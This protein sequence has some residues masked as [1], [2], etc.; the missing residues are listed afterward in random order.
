M[1]FS[2][3]FI[4]A[5]PCAVESE[6]QLMTTAK[7]VCDAGAS[8]LRGGAFKPRTNPQSFQGLG[9]E[10]LKLLAKAKKLTGLPI[11]TEVLDTRDV[12]LIAE[13]AD[14]I[15]I[16]SRSTQNYPL[17]KEVAKTKK[18]II[19]KRGMAMTVEEWLLAAQYILDAGHDQILLCERGIRTFETATRHT[20]DLNVVPLLKERTKFTVIVDP[21]H[22]TGKASLV[23]PMAKAALACGADGLM[24]EVH[25]NPAKALSDGQQSLDI[26]TF[27][28]L[29]KEIQK[30][31]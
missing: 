1:E 9:E 24:I 10:G 23:P 3:P 29:M 5:G 31:S 12:T 6:E 25:P 15:Q 2:K 8:A 22:G 19:L 27:E 11:V 14:I 30:T 17:L 4:I 21:S 13:Y 28:K 26:P 16:G 20:L 18:P 7:A